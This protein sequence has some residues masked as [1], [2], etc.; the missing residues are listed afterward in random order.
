M[1]D[2]ADELP[3]TQMDYA[4]GHVVCQMHDCDLFVLRI[5]RLVGQKWIVDHISLA[6]RLLIVKFCS[7]IQVHVLLNVVF[8]HRIEL[9]VI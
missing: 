7:W 2:E 1:V 8:F 3:L 6:D 4:L 5:E 9:G